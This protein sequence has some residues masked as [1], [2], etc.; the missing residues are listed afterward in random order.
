MADW[1]Y[2]TRQGFIGKAH[3]SLFKSIMYQ[4]LDQHSSFFEIVAPFYRGFS[5]HEEQNHID[6]AAD[7]MMRMLRKIS[8]SGIAVMCI[9]DA[10]DEADPVSDE[11]S[12]G[13]IDS[14]QSTI[15]SVLSK[16]I[17]DISGSGLKFIVLSRPEALIERE[18][19]QIQRRLSN[20]FKIVLEH[21]NQNDIQLIIEKGLSAVRE[22]IHAYDSEVDR[23]VT[24]HRRMKKYKGLK[25]VRQDQ[26]HSEKRS[27]QNIHSYLQEH[28]SGVI[29]WVTLALGELCILASS[30]LSTFAQL[31]ERVKA[32]PRKLDAFYEHIVE[33]LAT[34]STDEDLLIARQTFLLIS[35]SASLGRPIRLG[36]LWEALAVPSDITLALES[37]NDPIMGNR[38]R[39]NSWVGFRRQLRRKCGPLI[40]VVKSEST[41]RQARLDDDSDAE[42]DIGPDYVVQF[43]HRTVKDFLQSPTRQGPLHFSEK[44]STEMVEGVARRYVEIGFPKS[45]TKYYSPSTANTDGDWHA[46]VGNLSE[47]LENRILLR[48]VLTI[49][50]KESTQL[51]GS[52]NICTWIDSLFCISPDIKD[53]NQVKDVFRKERAFYPKCNTKMAG[54]KEAL[55]NARSIM[56]GELIRHLCAKGL[57]V[58]TDN[59]LE[60]CHQ[61]KSPFYRNDT[62]AIGN[63][64][65]LAAI[66]QDLVGEVGLLT[67]RQRH[68]SNLTSVDGN[69]TWPVGRKKKDKHLDPFIALA[70]RAGSV[71]IIDYLFELTDGFYAREQA[72]WD[73]AVTNMNLTGISLSDEAEDI[74]VTDPSAYIDWVAPLVFADDDFDGLYRIDLLEQPANKRQIDNTSAVLGV[75]ELDV[76]SARVSPAESLESF[77]AFDIFHR[78][79]ESEKGQER[80]EFLQLRAGCIY[81]A[82]EIHSNSRTAKDNSSS[83]SSQSA[84]FV[85]EDVE[86]AIRTVMDRLVSV[87]K[88]FSLRLVLIV[89]HRKFT[90]QILKSRLQ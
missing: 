80:K 70:V 35:G 62:Y 7:D 32:L 44:A 25:T 49:L 17:L 65:L 1:F 42:D 79:L 63:G 30:G 87:P 52:L 81:L 41:V 39:F 57:T 4:L 77:W 76:S 3:L 29:L 78:D 51:Q 45:Q 34:Q 11:K 5:S 69:T 43:M 37:Q 36:E 56:L 47:L 86:E 2:T 54:A 12:S 64:A 46:A 55:E 31:E 8:Q 85:L 40:D 18:Y 72:V 82:N 9:I 26:S 20:T 21:A 75:Q 89:P 33:D 88:V 14:R 28:A 50:E 48:F 19:L 15:L 22:A 71:K 66:E 16:L 27:L 67:R 13:Y 60:L 90:M 74:D 59:V 53:I 24:S 6:W 23:V 61:I 84:E 83:Q 10:M 68:Q 73:Y 58:G 38:I